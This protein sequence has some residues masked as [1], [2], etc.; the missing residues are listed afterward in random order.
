MTININNCSDRFFQI[1]Y[2]NTRA[3][4]CKNVFKPETIKNYNGTVATSKFCATQT[5]PTTQFLKKLRTTQD[6]AILS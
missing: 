4:L 2:L 5:E 3:K 1:K 6:N